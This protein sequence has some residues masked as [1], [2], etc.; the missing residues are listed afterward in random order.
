MINIFG[1]FRQFSA[2]NGVFHEHQSYDELFC[3]NSQC[4]NFGEIFTPIFS[5]KVFF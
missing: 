2:K 1:D 4:V 5:A 3:T